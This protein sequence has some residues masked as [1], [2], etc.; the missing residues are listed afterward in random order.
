ML[1]DE[2][3]DTGPTLLRR[4]LA[5]GP[6]RPP[7]SSS[8]ASPAWAPSCCSR[9]CAAWPTGTLAARPQD[10]ARA[11]LA[12]ILKKEDGRL[13]WSQPARAI[14]WRVRGFVPWPGAFT[15]HD[16]RLLKLLRVRPRDASPGSID[17]GPVP[18]EILS[19]S[20]DGV[21]VACGAGTPL[22]FSRYSRRADAPCRPPRGRP[23][24]GCGPARGSAEAVPSPAQT[25]RPRRARPACP[26]A[27]RTLARGARCSR[28]RGTRRARARAP[29]RARARYAAPPRLARSRPRATSSTRPLERVA[30]G[31]PRRAP[32]RRLPAAVH[33][34]AA[35]RGASPSPSSSH[36]QSSRARPAS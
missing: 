26:G 4:G 20:A 22:R 32:P 1:I 30:P 17:G 10:H 7:Q 9:P 16:G 15:L 29:A 34:R 36:A 21:T 25:L 19:V 23:A 33:A 8:R 12:P 11:T 27:E 13:D 24:P 18:G 6:R 3:L 35:A 14:A 2:G 28:G 31:R 5:I